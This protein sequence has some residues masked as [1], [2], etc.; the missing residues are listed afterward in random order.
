MSG[1]HTYR[2]EPF[3]VA[4][5]VSNEISGLTFRVIVGAACPLRLVRLPILRSHFSS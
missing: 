4:V 5:I 1:A 2:A 3:R